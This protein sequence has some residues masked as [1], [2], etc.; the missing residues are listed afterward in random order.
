MAA[1]TISDA[2]VT[3]ASASSSSALGA[4]SAQADT[5]VIVGHKA[6]KTANTGTVY[7]RKASGTVQIPIEPGD[8]LSVDGPG[9]EE[10]TLDQWEIHNVT[11][12]DGCGY[13]A[14][15]HAPFG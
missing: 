6:A 10:F 7:L 2:Y 9:G 14:I 13:V 15:T 12:G 1:P 8:V 11:A 5:L 4:S 3:N